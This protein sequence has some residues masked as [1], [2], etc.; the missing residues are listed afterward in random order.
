MRTLRLLPHCTADLKL[1][2]PFPLF[3]E[4]IA[5][6]NLEYV[7]VAFNDAD[8]PIGYQ[9]VNKQG[10]YTFMECLESENQV[11]TYSA[12][13]DT[14]KCNALA[15]PGD[16]MKEA[17][18]VCGI[19]ALT[20]EAAKG[21]IKVASKVGTDGEGEED[22]V[23]TFTPSEFCFWMVENWADMLPDL[24]DWKLLSNEDFVSVMPIE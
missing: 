4:T 21:V 14:S 22:L 19:Y 8:I 6:P 20:V 1:D 24:T 2:E 11:S 17:K 16:L 13:V 23:E 9:A 7:I 15:I 12:M 18:R 3:V 10:F 5:D